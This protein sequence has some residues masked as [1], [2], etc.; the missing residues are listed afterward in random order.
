MYFR[1][2]QQ[3]LASIAHA[4][5]ALRDNCKHA[6]IKKAGQALHASLRSVDPVAASRIHAN[7][8]QRIQRALEVFL[9]TGKTMSDWQALDTSPLAHY[10]IHNIILAPTDRSRL[11]DLIAQ[12]F[13]Q[14]LQQ[15]FVAEVERLYQRGD[16]T[17]EMPSIRSVGYRQ[18]WQYLAGDIPYDEMKNTAIAA[19]RQLAKRQLTWL[20]SWGEAQWFESEQTDLIGSVSHYFDT[21]LSS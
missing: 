11:H 5:A 3:G 2:L 13:E 16:L 20:R 19:T 1:V 6:P 9:L 10:D 15:G 21:L 12:R 4:D 8:S 14:M 17:A 18:A 7:D